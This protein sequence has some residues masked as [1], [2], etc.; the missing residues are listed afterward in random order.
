MLAPLDTET[1]T[2]KTN[3][4]KKEP[5]EVKTKLQFKEENATNETLKAKQKTQ[6]L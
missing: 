6:K 5:K 2:I 1:E 4:E 3:D